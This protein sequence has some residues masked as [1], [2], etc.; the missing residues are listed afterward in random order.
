MATCEPL[1][2]EDS[3]ELIKVAMG[4]EKAD[5]A[6]LNTKLANVYTGELLDGCSISIKGK[7]IAYMGEDPD[8]TIGPETLC[9]DAKGKTVIP[10][11]IDGHAHL[12]WLF[13]ISEF[14]KY[15]M[16]GGTTTII[17]ETME[18]FPV[19]GYEGVLAF[20]ASMEDQ[21]IKILGT[22]P[23][24]VSVSKAAFGISRETARKLLTRKDILG[25]GESYWQG[26][27]QNPDK[28]LPIFEETLLCRK[29]LEGHSAG[30]SGKKLAAYIA[31]GISSCHEPINAEQVL[32][33]LRMGL[34]VMV[35]EGSIRRDLKEISKIKD[36]GA[37]LRRLIL[38]TDGV[39]PEELMEKG[40]MEFVLQKAID[41]GFDPMTAVQMATLNVAEHFSID[42]LVGGIAPGRYADMLIIPD[43]RKIEAE[44]VISNGRII[45]QEGDLAVSPREHVFS[46]ACRESVR[47]PKK[48]KPSDFSIRVNNDS[49]E[50]DVRI[51]EMVTDLVTKESQMTLPVVEREIRSDVN[52]DILK[53]AAIDRTHQPGRIFVGLIRGF[54]MKSGAMASSA[55]WDTSDIIVVGA[56]D[57]DMAF[58]VNR[59]RKLQGGAVVCA[60]EKILAELPL[61]V[62]GLIS[63]MPMEKIELRLGAIR[64]AVSELGVSFPDPLLTLVT[65]TCA[66]IPYL[67]ICEEGFVN[68]KDGKTLG[69]FTD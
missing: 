53:V 16:K 18:V 17:T 59:I 10:G 14:L 28:M 40:Y 58:A 35:R 24:M 45:F 48:L 2:S 69:L 5:L 49:P 23:A 11:L 62:L 15:A 7:R 65:L 34:H 25:L 1:C 9:I 12:S 47:L 63:D 31:S 55:A 60:D 44:Y 13:N 29:T 51:I 27:F 4:Q 26:V 38:V 33:R 3:K 50:A 22:A 37:D 67:R 36:M 43:I 56:E 66:A 54:G 64:E 21:P 32:E 57:S 20:L 68:L 46:E 6:I 8:H 19:M 61:P 52:Q 41:S 39:V 42:G 30:A